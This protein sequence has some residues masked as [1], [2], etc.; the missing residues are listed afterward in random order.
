MLLIQLCETKSHDEALW[1]FS[2]DLHGCL[3]KKNRLVVPSDSALRHDILDDCHR[4]K[5]TTH[6]GSSKMYADMHRL[7]Y[8]EGMKPDV[9]SY[10]SNCMTCQRINAEHQR[11]SGLL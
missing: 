2:I 7:Y 6:P 4:S 3:R 5:Y 10:V 1:D 8:W 11:P 9:A